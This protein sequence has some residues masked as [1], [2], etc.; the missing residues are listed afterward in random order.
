MSQWKDKPRK[1]T[2]ERNSTRTREK[3]PKGNGREEDPYEKRG[4]PEEPQEPVQDWKR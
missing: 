2:S 4:A 3:T 1:R